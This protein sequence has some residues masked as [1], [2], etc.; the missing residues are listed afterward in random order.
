MSPSINSCPGIWSTVLEYQRLHILFVLATN[1]AIDLLLRDLSWYTSIPTTIRLL[2]KC[3]TKY[4][5]KEIELT[6][7]LYIYK[8]Y[9]ICNIKFSNFFLIKETIR[10]ILQKISV[11]VIWRGI[12]RIYNQV[13]WYIISHNVYHSLEII[14]YFNIPP[15]PPKKNLFIPCIKN[16]IVF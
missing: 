12:L 15:S 16:K 9:C 5:V 14:H 2:Y 11:E 4:D 1:P 13:Y 10:C 8:P 7:S 3:I 6:T